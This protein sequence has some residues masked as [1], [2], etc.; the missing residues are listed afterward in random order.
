MIIE[1]LGDIEDR[2]RYAAL[3]TLSFLLTSEKPVAALAR[4]P[5]TTGTTILGAEEDA[6][7]WEEMATDLR[8]QLLRLLEVRVC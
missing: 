4:S 2:V 1:R 6:R 7:R 5:K 8:L 3:K